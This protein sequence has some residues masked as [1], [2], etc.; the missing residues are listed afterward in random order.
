[1]VLK[2][3]LFRLKD[4]L[5]PTHMWEVLKCLHLRKTSHGKRVTSLGSPYTF[6]L[7][8]SP[9]HKGNLS[10]SRFHIQT[11]SSSTHSHPCHYRCVSCLWWPWCH[12]PGSTE[13]GERSKKQGQSIFSRE[14]SGNPGASWGWGQQAGWSVKDSE[15][16]GRGTEWGRHGQGGHGATSQAEQ[17]V[18]DE[19]YPVLSPTPPCAF[20]PSSPHSTRI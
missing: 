17:R 19:S 6:T 13:G 18:K 7:R 14:E 9:E 5:A 11:T 20:A 1:M 4:N 15:S 3:S 2:W 8:R 16:S 12:V 10:T